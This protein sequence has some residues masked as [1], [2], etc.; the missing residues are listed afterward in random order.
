VRS[1]VCQEKSALTL[2]S[3]FIVSLS[4]AMMGWISILSAFLNLGSIP[5]LQQIRS[6]FFV[7][8]A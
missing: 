7:Y 3:M 1:V 5:N 4:S 8:W 2:S 6:Q